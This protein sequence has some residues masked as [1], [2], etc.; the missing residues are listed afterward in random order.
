MKATGD[1]TTRHDNS[2]GR[3]NNG[4]GQHGDMPHN[5]GDSRQ[6]GKERHDNAAKRLRRT[7]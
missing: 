6:H 4:K 5:D 7:T 3:H 1:T 2:D